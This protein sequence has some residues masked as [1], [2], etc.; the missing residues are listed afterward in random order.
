MD[1][2]LCILIMFI[3]FFIAVIISDIVH[4]FKYKVTIQTI[5]KIPEN[6]RKQFFDDICTAGEE[7]KHTANFLTEE[8]YNNEFGIKK[9]SKDD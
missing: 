5:A 4:Y 8:E 7:I 1:N 9:D 6:E 3:V 2:T